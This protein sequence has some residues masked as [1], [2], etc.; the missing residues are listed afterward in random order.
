MASKK[1]VGNALMWKL[2]ERFGVQ[3]SQ[4]VLQL[5]L[6]RLLDPEH[7][8]V[9]S[10]MIIFTTLANVFIQNGFNTAL[11]QNKDVTERDYSSVFWVTLAVAG[12]LYGGL[13]LAAPA[14]AQFYHMPD[15]VAPFRV[16]CLILFPGAF[17]SIQ[18]AHVSRQMDFRKVFT[19]NLAGMLIAG[20]AGI[21]VAMM[22]GGLW[23]L[24]VQQ[25]L[26]VTIA[27]AVMCFTVKW[28][29]RFICDLSRVGVLFSYGW[30]LLLSGLM[31]TL[32]QE[33]R[34]LVIGKK[35]NSGTLGHYNRGKQFPQFI[36][37][38]VNTTVRSVMLPVISS[39]QQDKGR[40]KSMMRQSITL[41]SYLVFPVMAGL[42]GV[43][44]PLVRLLLT[45]KW[46]PC[47]PYLQIYC[48]SYA[49]YPVHSCNL[50]AINAMGR[51]DVFLILEIIKKL[52]G[53][54][55]LVGAVV[56]FKSP[57]AIAM[58]GVITA[59]TSSFINAFPNK[60]LV[61]YSYLEQM[62]D[63]LPSLICALLMFGSVWAVQLLALG[64]LATLAIQLVVGVGVYVG[65]SALIR[66][67]PF[68]LLT[69]MLLSRLKKQ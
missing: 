41:S 11:I 10:L 24:I 13:F 21:A 32:Y 25:L 5:V 38:A 57:I 61:N 58:T 54:P 18:L 17:N 22:G 20:V 7:Y 14:I 68:R 51:S 31:D 55:L 49:F 37:N 53:I 26:N 47:V 28:R 6:A 4:F 50:Q 52:V 12:V 35:Y 39:E 42:A 27:C 9:L 8:G 1:T 64:S 63:V 34:S 33:L 23:A 56:L 66:L 69:Q 40:V 65:L 67:E 19:S 15:L 46:L 44:E 2:L 62:K 60:K 43:A 45:D 59:F 16:L 30:K 48:F 29:P 36:I 3:G